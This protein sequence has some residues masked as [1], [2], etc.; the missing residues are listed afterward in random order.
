MFSVDRDNLNVKFTDNS[1]GDIDKYTWDFGDNSG[2]ENS[3]IQNPEHSYDMIG[4]YLVHLSV[5]NT[6][7]GSKSDEYKLINVGDIQVL[8]AA[9][10]YKALDFNKKLSGY[11]VDMVSA[12]SGDGATVEWD[13]G[14]KQLKKG[15]FTVMDSTG[16]K[17]THYYGKPG[18]YNVCVRISDPI[19]GQS[20]TYCA[21]V[22]TKWGVGVKEGL[23]FTFDFDVYP[24]PFIDRTSINYVL[25]ESQYLE[26]VV[27]DQLGR[28]METLVK[29]TQES[30]NYQLSWETKTV[31]PGVYHL[32][33]ITS[34]GTITKQLIVTK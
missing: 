19:S 23:E 3:A 8:K 27:F 12:S 17:V 28:R 25:P 14:D 21:D 9:F 16:R 7:T 29:S 18:I 34:D 30:G 22:L 4:F 15:S 24:N 6:I 5:E 26:L 11:P 2:N 10:G 1:F 13:F 32:K 33:L 20:D 31:A